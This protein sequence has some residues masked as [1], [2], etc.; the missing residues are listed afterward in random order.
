L[1]VFHVDLHPFI[2]GYLTGFTTE[3]NAPILLT[4]SAMYALTSTC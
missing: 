2:C 4:T 1:L 3:I